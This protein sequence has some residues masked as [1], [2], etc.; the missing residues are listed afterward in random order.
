MRLLTRR[1]TT[2]STGARSAAALISIAAV[3]GIWAQSEPSGAASSAYRLVAA[4]K[5]KSPVG[6]VW[7]PVSKKPYIIEQGGTLRAAT[8]KNPSAPV[9]DVS[10]QI[11]TGGEQG[12][13]GAA[14]SNDGNKLY[15]DL[16][17]PKGTTEIREYEWKNNAADTATMRLLLSIDQ[18]Y[19]N[20]NGGGIFV[21]QAGLLWI[22]MGDGGSA[23]DPENRAQNLDSLL[24]KMLRIDPSPSGDKPYSIPSDR[25]EDDQKFGLTGYETHGAS[26]SMRRPSDCLSAMSVKTPTRK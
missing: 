4:A 18:P 21:D 14:F 15:V 23:G 9:L 25:V 13:L 8:L 22:G 19:A 20:H 2:T 7:H 1:F 26:T 5:A 10:K 12:L 3:V 17:N 16:T 11:S 6:V 24:G